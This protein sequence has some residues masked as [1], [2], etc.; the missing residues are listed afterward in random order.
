[1]QPTEESTTGGKR[2]Y[3]KLSVQW[4]NDV[5]C[6]ALRDSVLADPENFWDASKSPTSCSCKSLAATLDYIANLNK[7]ANQ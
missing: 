4:L 7:W 3:K 1:M 5:L 2:T 6:P